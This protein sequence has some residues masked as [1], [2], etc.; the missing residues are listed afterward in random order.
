MFFF[1][2]RHIFDAAFWC[3][4]ENRFPEILLPTWIQHL[5]VNFEALNSSPQNDCRLWI[6]D[7]SPWLRTP[8]W[9]QHYTMTNCKLIYEVTFM[10][11]EQWNHSGLVLLSPVFQT[12][13]VKTT[14]LMRWSTLD[15]KLS[16][17]QKLKLAVLMRGTLKRTKG[18]YITESCFGAR[19]WC[20][21]YW[22]L[23]EM[24]G[25]IH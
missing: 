18:H 23:W 22:S 9:Q 16:E 10:W 4:H 13:P 7:T 6:S 8:Q 20:Q 1:G 12:H 17:R 25:E 3:L 5:K 15:H 2:A 11:S 24:H 14:V 21:L 19:L